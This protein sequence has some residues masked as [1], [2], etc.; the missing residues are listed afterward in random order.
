MTKQRMTIMFMK[1]IPTYILPSWSMKP[2]SPAENYNDTEKERMN[3]T[4]R[5]VILAKLEQEQI[6]SR[7]GLAGKGGW[8]IFGLVAL[9]VAYYFISGGKLF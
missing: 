6:K 4:G 9:V 2:Y 5:R 8:I 1:N 7:K 3:M